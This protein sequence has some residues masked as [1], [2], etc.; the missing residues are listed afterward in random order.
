MVTASQRKR[1]AKLA[2][3]VDEPQLRLFSDPDRELLKQV[4]LGLWFIDK[5][6]GTDQADKILK[7]A[8]AAFKAV[9]EE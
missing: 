6:G 8:K 7:I 1:A 2:K 9:K 5:C 3:N 4:N